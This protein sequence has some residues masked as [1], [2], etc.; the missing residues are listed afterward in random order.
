MASRL[1]GKVYIQSIGLEQ[2]RCAPLSHSSYSSL[3]SWWGRVKE[4]RRRR[5]HRSRL[6]FQR[7]ALCTIVKFGGGGGGEEDEKKVEVLLR[8]RRRRR[9]KR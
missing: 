7:F 9:R 2:C 5:F 4:G 6:N 8:R 3:P 1:E